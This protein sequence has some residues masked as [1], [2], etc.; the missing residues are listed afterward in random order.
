MEIVFEN[1]IYIAHKITFSWN[2]F[3]ILGKALFQELDSIS[4]S[5]IWNL[6]LK[7]ELNDIFMMSIILKFFK[8]YIG[9]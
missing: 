1:H 5:F 3:L 4:T 2:N 7:F 6:M 9:L 8:D